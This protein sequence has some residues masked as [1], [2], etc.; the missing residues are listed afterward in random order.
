MAEVMAFSRAWGYE[1]CT[2]NLGNLRDFGIT[3]VQSSRKEEEKGKRLG[4]G[5][6]AV[7]HWVF[8]AP[9]SMLWGLRGATGSFHTGKCYDLVW[10]F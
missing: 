1:S 3:R 6:G 9:G 10:A 2:V 5:G 8:C 4:N 7:T